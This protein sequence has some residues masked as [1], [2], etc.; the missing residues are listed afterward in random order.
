VPV[1][2]QQVPLFSGLSQRQ[3]KR[4]SRLFKEHR[5]KAGR[6]VVKQGEMS[7]IRFFVISEGEAS[8]SVDGR[9]VRRLGPGDHFGEFALISRQVRA[10]TVTAETPLT[11]Q[12]IDFWDFRSFAN[13]NP[14]ILWKLLE[15][16]VGLVAN[17]RDRSGPAPAQTI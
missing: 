3:L 14:E 12:A 15:H 6:P 2:L 11:C 13:D 8:V 10:A 9:E 1:E 5:V 16:V 7:G 17:E 4:L